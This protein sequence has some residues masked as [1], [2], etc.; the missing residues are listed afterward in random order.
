MKIEKKILSDSKYHN[1]INSVSGTEL[2]NF[3]NSKKKW[4]VTTS[5][6]K[7]NHK[8]IK[9]KSNGGVIIND[10]SY[11]ENLRIGSAIHCK[12][13]EPN[14]FKKMFDVFD[15]DY[16]DVDLTKKLPVKYTKLFE[17]QI[18]NSLKS[19]KSY[20]LPHEKAN[21]D[22][23]YDAVKNHLMYNE[24]IGDSLKNKLTEFQIIIKDIEFHNI[25]EEKTKKYTLK[26][27]L[28]IVNLFFNE[29]KEIKEI[30]IGDIKTTSKGVAEYTN[31]YS[32]DKTH[33]IYQ[34]LYY[35]YLVTEYIKANNGEF[36]GYKV[37]DDYTVNSYYIVI[38]KSDQD[39]LFMNV[40]IE[41]KKY[42]DIKSNIIEMVNFNKNMLKNHKFSH[43]EKFYDLTYK[44]IVNNNLNE[45]ITEEDYF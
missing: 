28:D 13:L 39:V 14:K 22:Y 24:T 25:L 26:G 38:K 21:V 20:L 35:E 41:N 6:N 4:W 11:N 19:G 36:A 12:L 43:K 29:K 44:K 2:K 16:S 23:M 33:N 8:K 3:I 30:K 40:V 18:E 7:D 31:I 1:I 10:Y 34:C 5:F 17:E 45:V 27:K 9:E 32:F 15:G 37:A 42:D